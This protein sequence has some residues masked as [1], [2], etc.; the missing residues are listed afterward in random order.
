MLQSQQ[1]LW[2][3]LPGCKFKIQLLSSKL[4]WD[5]S[6]C[7]TALS[8]CT[9]LWL[10]SE[11]TL[12]FVTDCKQ[13]AINQINLK[14]AIDG[15]CRMEVLPKHRYCRPHPSGQ[16]R[17]AF[18]SCLKISRLPKLE[19]T[20][21]L[22]LKQVAAAKLHTVNITT[23]TCVLAMGNNFSDAEEAGSCNYPSSSR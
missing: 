18:L 22:T 10:K 20:W 1:K 4:L 21:I 8:T 12:G 23:R 14:S 16:F 6:I 11:I 3:T 7:S 9:V 15:D 2:L 5:L 13:G 17:T 19:N